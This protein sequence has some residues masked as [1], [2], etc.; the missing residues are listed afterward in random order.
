MSEVLFLSRVIDKLNF[1]NEKGDI[2]EWQK[3][4]K[5]ETLLTHETEIKEDVE[6]M[7]HFEK[8]YEKTKKFFGD[9]MIPKEEFF[10]IFCRTWI[11]S[12][13]IHTSAGT[14]IGIALDLGE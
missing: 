3:E 12:H 6:K 8:I 14:E 5:F 4:R 1:L 13:S 2:Y 7:K 11:N 9:K 10:L